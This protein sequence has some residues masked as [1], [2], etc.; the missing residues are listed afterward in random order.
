MLEVKGEGALQIGRGHALGLGA[1]VVG[2]TLTY[3]E[4]RKP[5][6][7]SAIVESTLPGRLGMSPEVTLESKFIQPNG[8]QFE[9]KSLAAG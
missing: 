7:V 4:F 2:R 6:Q 9:N 1:G 5:K 3:C 8:G